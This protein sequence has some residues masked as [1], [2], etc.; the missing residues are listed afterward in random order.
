MDNADSHSTD[1]RGT[2]SPNPSPDRLGRFAWPHRPF[3]A[4]NLR[5]APVA[6]ALLLDHIQR[7][8]TEVER[9]RAPADLEVGQRMR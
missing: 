5:H 7:I 3:P 2:P 4:V 8:Q 1:H 6:I 9:L